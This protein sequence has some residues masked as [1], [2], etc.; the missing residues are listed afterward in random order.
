MTAPPLTD[1]QA[2]RLEAN[3]RYR[4]RDG[5]GTITIEV[6]AL[7]SLLDER[8]ELHTANAQIAGHGTSMYEELGAMRACLR[9]LVACERLRASI[10]EKGI[11]WKQITEKQADYRRRIPF[12]WIAAERL[13]GGENG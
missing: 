7:I 1:D 8:K 3:A 10:R 4:M 13:A 6:A 12:A 2:D 11:S 9:E 5:G